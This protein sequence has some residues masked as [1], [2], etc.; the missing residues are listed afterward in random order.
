MEYEDVVPVLGQLNKEVFRVRD[1]R[2]GIRFYASDVL[3]GKLRPY[4]KNWLNPQF[5]GVALGDF[6]VLTAPEANSK[7]LY[8]LIQTA[9]FLEAA[10][11]S[12][13]T[14]MPRAD[15]G[16]VSRRDFAIAGDASE[17]KAIGSLFRKLDSLITLHQREGCFERYRTGFFPPRPPT[18]SNHCNSLPKRNP[19]PYSGS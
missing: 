8:S 17:Q 16:N 9:G 2:E 15:W 5:D 3:F 14:K 4:L 11:E 18:P 1:S 6:W 19:P 7:F 12:T 13:G 10:N